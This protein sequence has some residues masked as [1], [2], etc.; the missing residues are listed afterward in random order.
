MKQYTICCFCADQ[1]IDVIT[2]FAVITNVVIKRVHC[3]YL[4]SLVFSLTV[5]F[6]GPFETVFQ[7]VSSLCTERGAKERGM[8]GERKNIQLP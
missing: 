6:D 7:S 1:N 4:L 3:I 5:G 8:V 2:H